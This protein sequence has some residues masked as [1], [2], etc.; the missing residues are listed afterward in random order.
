MASS[1]KFCVIANGEFETYR[2]GKRKGRTK[3]GKEFRDI[4]PIIKQLDRDVE[5]SLKYLTLL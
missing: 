1:Y 4:L 5:S 3:L 2:R